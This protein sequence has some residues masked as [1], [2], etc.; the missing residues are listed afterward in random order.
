MPELPITIDLQHPVTVGEETLE[1]LVIK[2]RPKA[3]DL[4]AMDR[5]KGDVAK[6]C[7]LIAC[8]AEIPDSWVEQL[9]SSDFTRAAEVV[10]DF[11]S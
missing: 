5:H 1:R 7:A 3:K 2:R 6:T 9:D 10:G 4:K 8:L 11:L